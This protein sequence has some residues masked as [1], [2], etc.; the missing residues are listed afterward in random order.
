MSLSQVLI[1]PSSWRQHRRDRS[2]ERSRRWGSRHLEAAAECRSTD[3]VSG[4]PG[5]RWEPNL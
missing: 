5:E 2:Q 4:D 1:G 3:P